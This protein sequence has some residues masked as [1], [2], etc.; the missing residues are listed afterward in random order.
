MDLELKT[1]ESQAALQQHLNAHFD[2]LIRLGGHS[3]HLPAI[4]TPAPAAPPASTT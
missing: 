2:E 1:G 4:S 3:C